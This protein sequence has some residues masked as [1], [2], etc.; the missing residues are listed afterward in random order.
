[1][2]IRLEISLFA[3]LFHQIQ[4]LL[5]FGHGFPLFQVDHDDLVS[6]SVQ[7]PQIQLVYAAQSVAVDDIIVACSLEN[8]KKYSANGKQRA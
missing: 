3:D 2:L 8:F 1:M 6:G 4:K 5:I 7:R